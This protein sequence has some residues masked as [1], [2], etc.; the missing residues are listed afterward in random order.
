M[1]SKHHTARINL[2][3]HLL[4]VPC[5]YNL[6]YPR[7]DSAGSG[8]CEPKTNANGKNVAVQPTLEC[9]RFSQRASA[10]V[11]FHSV[12]TMT[13]TSTLTNRAKEGPSPIA[14]ALKS[15]RHCRVVQDGAFH[16]TCVCVY[17]GNYMYHKNTSAFT[18][19][20][21][22]YTTF[23]ERVWATTSG[24][25]ATVVSL[26]ATENQKASKMMLHPPTVFNR[27]SSKRKAVLCFLHKE[28]W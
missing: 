13:P 21:A 22:S 3:R 27:N 24:H 9:S 12:N 16:E 28:G 18:T 1:H 11:L 19:L 23:R 20:S 8:F 10:H 25:L 7:P 4:S 5:Y 15:V 17:K 14:W 6:L 2:W 26:M